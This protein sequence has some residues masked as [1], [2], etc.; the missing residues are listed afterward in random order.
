M[1]RELYRQRQQPQP[2]PQQPQQPQGQSPFPRLTPEDD[3]NAWPAGVDPN[4]FVRKSTYEADKIAA[5]RRIDAALGALDTEVASKIRGAVEGSDRQFREL[6]SKIN[7]AQGSQLS[8]AE[9][10]LALKAFGTQ[11]KSDVQAQIDAGAT[12]QEAEMT[13]INTQLD[14]L[15]A[16]NQGNPEKLAAIDKAQAEIESEIRAAREEGRDTDYGV[17]AGI[18]AAAGVGGFGVYRAGT[19]K[20][21]AKEEARDEA[22]SIVN[23]VFERLDKD[24]DGLPD[25][26]EGVLSSRSPIAHKMAEMVAPLIIN[27]LSPDY[28]TPSQP[29]QPQARPA[30]QPQGDVNIPAIIRETVKAVKTK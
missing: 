10:T 20:E 28:F 1:E 27:R 6:T 15:R 26:V 29:V 30:P 3:P 23:R 25:V 18:L 24:R 11:L 17:I 12:R 8:E 16:A 9:M 4:D 13:V 14:N 7:A 21:K 19:G 2:Q 5:Q 22:K